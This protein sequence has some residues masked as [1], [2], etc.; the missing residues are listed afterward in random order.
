MN[1][2]FE[3]ARTI[4]K[5]NK[6]LKGKTSI[7][8]GPG[9]WGST[10]ADLGIPISYSDIYNTRAL[11]ELSGKNIGS[12]PEPSLGTHFFQDLLEAQIYPLAIIL[13]DLQSIFQPAFFYHSPNALADF[14]P[15]DDILKER[16][17]VIEVNKYRKNHSLR[18]IMNEE[19]STAIGY[20]VAN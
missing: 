7:F 10:N 15:A 14:I 5:V 11:I 3:L 18:L 20:L 17:R 4:G 16:L 2:R 9:R 1:E 13:D 6:A 19:H 12:A 8:I